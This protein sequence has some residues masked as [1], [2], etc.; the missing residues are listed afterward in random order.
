VSHGGV[1]CECLWIIMIILSDIN[2]SNTVER[3]RKPT[4]WLPPR[5]TESDRPTRYYDSCLTCSKPCNQSHR[6]MEESYP[7]ERADS[8]ERGHRHQCDKNA[9]ML[10]HELVPITHDIISSVDI[11]CFTHPLIQSRRK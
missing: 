2:E 8:Y 6:C 5:V 11:E 3:E 9:V 7:S 4:R 1:H 10:L